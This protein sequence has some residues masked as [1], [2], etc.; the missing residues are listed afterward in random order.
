MFGVSCH[1]RSHVGVTGIRPVVN[2]LADSGY[3][4]QLG[5]RSDYQEGYRAGF[6]QGYSDG[7]GRR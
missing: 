7:Y 4:D 5:S 1:G 2:L 3:S 6:R